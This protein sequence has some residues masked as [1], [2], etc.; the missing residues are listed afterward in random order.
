MPAT[1]LDGDPIDLVTR[2]LACQRDHDAPTPL[3]PSYSAL[4]VLVLCSLP[5]VD[6]SLL[7]PSYIYTP[8]PS[9]N[10]QPSFSLLLSGAHCSGL[11]H[12]SSLY[13][14]SPW[15]P[16]PARPIIA[17]FLL[18]LR[19]LDLPTPLVQN[20]TFL[21]FFGTMAAL[22][23]T[24]PTRQPLASLDTPRMRTLMRSKLNRQNGQNGMLIESPGSVLNLQDS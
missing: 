1:R 13:F 14:L 7:S 5:R 10:H 17:P 9:S 20:K 12:P 19:S 22:T 11:I 23:M 18:F 3:R 4:L 16:T 24:P 2:R 6:C 8:S 21:P 15:A